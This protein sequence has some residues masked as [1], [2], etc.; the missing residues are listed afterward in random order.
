MEEIL[1][2]LVAMPTVTDDIAVN[3]AALDYIET[4]LKTRGLH[5]KRFRFDGHGSL[6]ATTR[7]HRLRPT[8]M[9]AAHVDVVVAKE[10]Q[11]TLQREADK[12]IGRG[13][14][15]MKC[16]I[17]AYL[18][19]VDELQ[20]T[21]DAY[22]FGIMITTDEE[23]GGVDGVS[24][25]AKLLEHGYRPVAAV[26]PDGA[27]D[28]KVETLAKGSWRFDL[29]AH[30]KTAHS[31]RPW[32]GDSASAKLVHA[33]SELQTRFKDQGPGTNTLNI[34]VLKG[35]RA[36]NQIP[37]EMIAYVE[38]RPLSEELL[39]ADEDFLEDLCNR[40]GLTMQTRLKTLPSREDP[41][42]PFIKGLVAGI[43]RVTGEP[44]GYFTSLASSDCVHFR[45]YGVA[46]AVT[47]LPGGGHHSDYEWVDHRSFLQFKDVLLDYLN[48]H[49]HNP[50][51][52]L[53]K[54]RKPTLTV[55]A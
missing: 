43:Q 27:S 28:W 21:L 53:P 6:V 1:A 14:F 50:G 13:V 38:I 26:L 3:D 37:D 12:L 7:G 22:D 25:V 55:A 42:H 8:V 46:C 10:H 40:Y 39:K 20:D 9:L 49:A 11:Y 15:D 17:A 19:L 34:G 44:S 35:G 52:L 54:Q 30:G 41:D 16:S 4:Y 47:Y 36:R 45:A 32:L 5:V 33:L 23:A 51:P 48:H 18:A 2:D 24:G 29:I 31:S